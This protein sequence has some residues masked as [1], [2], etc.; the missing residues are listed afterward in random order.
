MGTRDM[1][2]G[3]VLFTEKKKYY[4][5]ISPVIPEQ[6]LP[7]YMLLGDTFVL[8]YCTLYFPVMFPV[9]LTVGHVLCLAHLQV[10]ESG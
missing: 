1:K 5:R 4:K 7:S 10:S 9:G 6:P 3:R 2:N 8:Y